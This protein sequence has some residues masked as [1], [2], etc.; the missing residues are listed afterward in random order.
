MR[1]ALASIL[2]LCVGLP[3][4]A[5]EDKPARTHDAHAAAPS[6]DLCASGSLE[7][8]I[9][10]AVC[11]SGALWEVC[12]PPDVN[13]PRPWWAQGAQPACATAAP[14]PH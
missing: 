5:A 14:A 3:A 9:G 13:H 7:Y 4:V 2:A 6:P 10:G 12:Q 1:I 11:I 8:S